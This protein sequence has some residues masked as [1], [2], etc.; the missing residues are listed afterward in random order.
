MTRQERLSCFL[1]KFIGWDELC[2]ESE[3]FD[4]EYE[5]VACRRVSVMLFGCAAPDHLRCSQFL[6]GIIGIAR[7]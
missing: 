3:P 1:R 6:T 5:A 2:I 7:C 4:T